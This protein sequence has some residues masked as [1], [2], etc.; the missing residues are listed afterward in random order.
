MSPR[1][2]LRSF[3]LCSAKLC[4]VVQSVKAAKRK[5]ISN[6]KSD[7]TRA[8]LPAF[9]HLRIEMW[10]TRSPTIG[11]L[12]KLNNDLYYRDILYMDVPY[13]NG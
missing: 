12:D 4:F 1:A 2:R 10:G 8:W 13:E 9:P 11:L 7:S 3:I 5:S 6:N